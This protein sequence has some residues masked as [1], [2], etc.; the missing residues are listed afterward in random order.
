MAKTKTRNA[1]AGVGI[2]AAFVAGHEGMMLSA[3]RDVSPARV[4]SVCFGETEGVKM[5]DRYTAE[6]CRAMLD[7]R[8]WDYYWSA[9]KAIPSLGD[10]PP[11]RIAAIVSLN[12]N[13][14]PG[15]LAKSSV[16]R[17]LNAGHIEAGCNAFLK[18]DKAG[19]VTFRGLTRR[20]AEERALCLGDA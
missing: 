7:G 19:G 16:A 20:R 3:Y 5:G 1:V 6:Q 4:I 17:L 8:I 14:G 10:M 15:N 13:I 18:W 2:A 12:Y 9:Q 11:S